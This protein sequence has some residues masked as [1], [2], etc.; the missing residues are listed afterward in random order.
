M[1]ILDNL[2]GRFG[3]MKAPKVPTLAN[4]PSHLLASAR[5][6]R[7]SLPDMG[8][9]EEQAKLYVKLSWIN[10]AIS[11]TAETASLQKVHVLKV[12]NEKSTEIIDHEMEEL[13]RHPNPLHSQFEFFLNTFSYLALNGQAYWWLNKTGENKKPVEVWILPSHKVLPIPDDRL[14]ISGYAYDPGTGEAPV[15]L[16]VW[17][18]VHFKNF[19][20]LHEFIGL[21]SIE[22]LGTV[23]L[24]DLNAQDWTYR[25]FGENNAR[26]PGI[27]AFKDMIGDTTWEKIQGDTVEASKMRNFLMLRGVGDGV[28]W[29]QAAISQKDMQYIEQRDFTKNEI[30]SIYAPGYA[31]MVDVNATEANSKA[32]KQTFLEFAVYPRLVAVGQ[33]VTQKLCPLYG[34]D[35][36]MEFEDPRQVDRALE[37][38]EQK[39]YATTHTINEIREQ[40]YEDEPLDDDRGLLLPAQIGAAPIAM[41]VA[42]GEEPKPPPIPAPELFTQERDRTGEYEKPP[43]EREESPNAEDYT[44]AP[45]SSSEKSEIQQDLDRWQRKILSNMKRKGSAPG[46][47][48][49]ESQNIPLPIGSAISEALKT[50]DTPE[51]VKAIFTNVWI[52]YP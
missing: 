8:M 51:E 47:I 19:N 12:K 18:V 22:A 45:R 2:L 50:V 39:T 27:L 16:P 3:Y 26:L 23:S 48:N 38:E 7:W 52:G 43:E 36:R 20:P 31:S 11:K 14:Y 21:S 5:S 17:Q 13:F 33:K 6:A 29:I 10:G 41:E 15:R 24:T 49:F 35:L 34:S 25:Y 4:V 9:Y 44:P 32:G 30:Y 46:E 1:S 28:N 40:Y 42:T 37:I